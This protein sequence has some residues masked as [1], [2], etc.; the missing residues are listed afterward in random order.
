MRLS[1]SMIYQQNLSSI[2]NAYSKWQTTGVQLATGMR[3][4]SPADDPIASSQAIGLQNSQ[5]LGTQYSAARSNAT[6][7]VSLETTV[8]SQVTDVIHAIQT[9]LVQAGDGTLSD[10]DR[11]SLSTTL[12]SYKDQLLSLANSKDGNGNYIFAGYKTDT[13]PFVADATTGAVSY[14]GGTKAI[15]Q[16]VDDSSEMTIGD[17]G[18]QVFT[19]LSAGYTVEPDGSASESNIFN[20]IDTALGALNTP[21]EDADA[22]TTAAYSADMGKAA[23]GMTNSLNNM[24]TVQSSLGSKLNQLDALNSVGT[25]RSTIYETRISD[26]T[27][28]DWY[29]TVSDYSLQQVALQA[30]YST[31]NSMQKLSLFQ[32][33]S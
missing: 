4:N 18:D 13:A 32:T 28:A 26:L 23:R 8:V 14:V 3:V 10:K 19:H 16:K 33:N 21:Q 7:S 22:A 12:Q 25:D 27:G 6:A 20:S 24:L 31:F 30:A 29:S 5:A 11:Q 15:S 9:K 2:T 1:T 17:T